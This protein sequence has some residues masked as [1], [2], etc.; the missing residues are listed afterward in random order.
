M[1]ELKEEEIE[2]ERSEDSE[3]S[4]LR[5]HEEFIDVVKTK[6]IFKSGSVDEYQ[7]CTIVNRDGSLLAISSP[8]ELGTLVV[9]NIP[10]LEVKYTHVVKT[11]PIS[12]VH[13]DPDTGKFLVYAT[14]DRLVVL[15]AVTGAEVAHA[16]QLSLGAA[17][18]KVRFA[19]AK[20]LIAGINQPN[21]KGVTLAQYKFTG[22]VPAS[23]KKKKSE[24]IVSQLILVQKRQVSSVSSITALDVSS[25]SDGFIAF[26][27]ADLTVT[28]ASLGNLRPQ[29]TWRDAHPFA[30]TQVVINPA[31]T[32]VASTSVAN[33]VQVADLPSDGIFDRRR[34]TVYWTL[35]S[36]LLLILTAIIFQVVVKH[37]V[38][39]DMEKFALLPSTGGAS[40]AP[41]PPVIS[42]IVKKQ[43]DVKVVYID[44]DKKKQEAIHNSDL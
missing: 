21:R 25:K 10:S 20:S 40:S 23:E 8:Q 26:A 24:S 19:D 33:T 1:F 4:E 43:D 11:G 9:L 39:G 3:G 7:K 2:S 28:V 37:S 27:R 34:Q 35:A 41:H 29:Q 38:F 17:F 22:P 15:N 44:D 5:V 36:A 16:P 42:Q 18:S 32:L 6:A 30:V 12:D 14:P 13:F 31:G